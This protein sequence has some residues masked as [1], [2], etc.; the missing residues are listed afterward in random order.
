MSATIALADREPNGLAEMLAG[1]FEANLASHPRRE[2]LL[3]PAVVDLEVVDAEVGATVR[4]SPG[5][6]E[7]AN[8]AADPSADVRIRARAQDLLAMAAAPLLFGLPN[9]LRRDGRSI[10]GRLLRRHVQIA[11]L[12]RHPVVVSRFARLLSVA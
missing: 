1:L 8:G 6:V 7:I 9:P 5:S 2:R 12:V 11:G 4:I 10:V 3:R